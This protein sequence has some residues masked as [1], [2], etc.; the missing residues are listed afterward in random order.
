MSRLNRVSSD[1]IK[2]ADRIA[3][4]FYEENV[5]GSQF[6]IATFSS[7]VNLCSDGSGLIKFYPSRAK[8]LDAIRRLNRSFNASNVEFIS[9]PDENITFRMICDFFRNSSGAA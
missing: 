5:S 4:V 1:A 7:L 2:N 6:A 9:D 3:I 8:A